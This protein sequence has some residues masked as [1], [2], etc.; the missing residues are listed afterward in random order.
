ML[1]TVFNLEGF[2]SRN[3][4]IIYTQTDYISIRDVFESETTAVTMELAIQLA[5]C[6]LLDN[7]SYAIYLKTLVVLTYNRM[8]I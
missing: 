4:N 7:F 8:F 2:F 6:S 1:I 5:Y 3:M